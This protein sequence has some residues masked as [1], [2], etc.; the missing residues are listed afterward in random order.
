[1]NKKGSIYIIASIIFLFDQLIKNCVNNIMNLYDKI[2]I[3]PGFFQIYFVKNTGAAFSIFKDN[4]LFIILITVVF[5][6][7]LYNYIKKERQFTKISILSLGMILGGI[8]GNL[9]D[10]IIYH[11]VID[12]LSFS[13]FK[14]DFPI[15]NLAD[16]AITLGVFIMLFE[17]IF[18]K[19][20]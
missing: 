15:F 16:I 5:I 12:Y 8:L 7:F 9:L 17:N 20:K 18:F 11:S 10:R 6:A 19:N 4:T 14:V 3:I 13:F 2:K 1:M